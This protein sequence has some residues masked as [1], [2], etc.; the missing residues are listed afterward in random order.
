M[1]AETTRPFS[2]REPF[3]LGE[4]EAHLW[5]VSLDL[6][7]D[8]LRVLDGVLS[9]D[10]R[11]RAGRFVVPLLGRRF[12]AARGALRTILSRYVGVEPGAI[13][14]S[15]GPHGKPSLAAPTGRDDVRFNMSHA[16][17]RAFVA[18]TKGREIGVDIE[19]IGMRRFDEEVARRFFSPS[20]GR[21]LCSAPGAAR[22]RLFASF[23]ARREAC[24]KASGFGLLFPLASFDVSEEAGEPRAIVSGGDV[25]H[26]PRSWTLVD[27]ETV[28][29]FAAACAVEG[30]VLNVIRMELRL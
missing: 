10:E 5:A 27:V 9:P 21:A 13:R 29:G 24:V 23:W 15:Y 28:P 18:V 2:A 1:S 4:G 7:D 30:A 8:P 3:E 6:D 14:F 12:V 16:R 11:E 17:D 25:T 22:E 19:S 26:A 20:D